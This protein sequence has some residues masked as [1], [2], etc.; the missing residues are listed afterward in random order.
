MGIVEEWKLDTF[1]VPSYAA[2]LEEIQHVIERERSYNINLLEKFELSWDAGSIDING[3]NNL[4]TRVKQALKV[5][6]FVTEP[7][8]ASHFGNSI[9]DD[10]FK[11][12]ST[13][14]KDSMEKGVLQEVFIPENLFGKV[15]SIIDKE[16]H[17]VCPVYT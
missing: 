7:I 10:L 6:R 5:I 12:L 14:A 2:S 9:M 11:R 17:Q 13:R 4:D 8:L 16:V 15:C 3:D 1:N